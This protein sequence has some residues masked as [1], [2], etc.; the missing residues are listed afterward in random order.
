MTTMKNSADKK[1]LRVLI[2]EDTLERQEALQ[3]LVKDHAWVLVHTASRAI[4]LLGSYEFDL[5]F[6]D[7]DL[8]GEERGDRVAAAISGSGNAKAKV[9]VHSMNDP[10]AKK[11]AG[12]LANVELVPFS[13]I[14]KSN[15]VFRKLQQELQRGVDIDWSFVFRRELDREE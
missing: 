3:R 6:L 5:I 9:I 12:V 13:K 8:A 15:A 2:I 4:R 10:G 14:T 1:T 7:F 11:I